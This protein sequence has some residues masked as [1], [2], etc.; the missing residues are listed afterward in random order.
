MGKLGN[1]LRPL[2][3]QDLE[4]VLQWRN[5]PEINR[6]MYNQTAISWEEHRQWFFRPAR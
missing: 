2:M 6:Y 3:E 4:M 1:G 5:H